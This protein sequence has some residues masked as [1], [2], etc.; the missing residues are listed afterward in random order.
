[1]GT[2]LGNV[3]IGQIQV[4]LGEAWAEESTEDSKGLAV[5]VV[6]DDEAL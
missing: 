2:G 1:M 4:A 5:L 3:H 6:G